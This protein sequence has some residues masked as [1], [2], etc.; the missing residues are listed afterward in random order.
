M[1]HDFWA[2][3]QTSM[4]KEDII[5]K[6]KQHYAEDFI[7]EYSKWKEHLVDTNENIYNAI[8]H[9]MPREQFTGLTFDEFCGGIVS[10]IEKYVNEKSEFTPYDVKSIIDSIYYDT[11]TAEITNWNT[12]KNTLD[13]LMKSIKKI[14]IS[15]DET[16]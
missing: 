1:V 2:L 10:R 9:L 16:P 13:S 14:V 6:A 8:A 5:D 7:D 15:E 12:K 3:D 11:M 4:S